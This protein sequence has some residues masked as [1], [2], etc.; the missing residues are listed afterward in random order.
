MK[1]YYSFALLIAAIGLSGCAKYKSSSVPYPTGFSQEAEDI[2]VVTRKLSDRECIT[3]FDSKTTAKKYDAVQMYVKN[4]RDKPIV[5]S[6]NKLD[7]EIENVKNISK[8]IYRNTAGRVAGYGIGAL[9][10]WPL[11]IPAAVD[12]AKSSK[13]NFEVDQDVKVKV[14]GQNDTEI[15]QPGAA[16]NKIFFVP[17][18]KMR[19]E[20]NV[21]LIEQSSLKEIGF[22]CMT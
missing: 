13:A 12:G 15:I 19:K 20:F 10:F 9:F 16:V 14:L 22:Y 1:K 18:D 5:L 2:Q 6:A 3:C 17:K 11:I 8:T 7:I 4:N 21:T